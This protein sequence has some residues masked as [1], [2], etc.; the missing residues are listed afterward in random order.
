MFYKNKQNINPASACHIY[1]INSIVLF[2][3]F[4]FKLCILGECGH[5][6]VNVVIYLLLSK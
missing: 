4:I 2:Y 6:G 1:L 5:F 3:I